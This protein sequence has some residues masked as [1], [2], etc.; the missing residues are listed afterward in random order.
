MMLYAEG[1]LIDELIG[2]DNTISNGEH[3]ELRLY[4]SDGI[5]VLEG[6]ELTEPI[7]QDAGIVIVKFVKRADSFMNIVAQSQG[8][9]GWQLFKSNTD[10]LIG[11][12]IIGL[13]VALMIGGKHGKLGINKQ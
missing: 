7:A 11:L 3:I 5:I 8:V 12:G 9:I 13:V 2:Y 6:L 1:L 4:L 10:I